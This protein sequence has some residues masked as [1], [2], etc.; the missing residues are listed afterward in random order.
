MNNEIIEQFII[1]NNQVLESQSWDNI[2]VS[3]TTIYEVIRV[4]S[5]VPLFVEDHFKRLSASAKAVGFELRNILD[6]IKANLKKLIAVNSFPEKNIKISV[7][8]NNAGY[9][10]ILYFIKSSYPSCEQYQHGVSVIT[11]HAERNNPNAKVINNSLR[12]KIDSALKSADAYEAILVNESSEITEGSRSN[13]FMS[14]NNSLY[15]APADM[16]LIGITRVFI[17]DICKKLGIQLVEQP[18]SLE[19][20]YKADGLFLTGTSPKVLP[21]SRVDSINYDSSNNVLIRQIIDSYNSLINQY[22][23]NFKEIENV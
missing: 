11:Y 22:T 15:T 13:I 1:Y 16:V 17:I 21:I 23:N 7:Y 2:I 8:K 4:I 3:G 9:N 14:A 12:E 19:F 20:L 18:V 10:Y 6:E 5:G